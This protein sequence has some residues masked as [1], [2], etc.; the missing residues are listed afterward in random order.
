[1][2]VTLEVMQHAPFLAYQ[3]TACQPLQDVVFLW[4]CRHVLEDIL[5]QRQVV[6]EL[7]QFKPLACIDRIGFGRSRK[8]FLEPS[9]LQVMN[10]GE[11]S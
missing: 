6:P 1:M 8:N 2:H 7:E 11:L 10:I 5:G 4:R 9:Q 3:A